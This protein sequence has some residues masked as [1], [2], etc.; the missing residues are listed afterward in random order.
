MPSRKVCIPEYSVTELAE[1]SDANASRIVLPNDV[2]YLVRAKHT[3]VAGYLRDGKP[4]SL[5]LRFQSF[6]IIFQ[7]DGKPWD[8][9]NVF[10]FK[11]LENTSSPN[12]GTFI[13][14]AEDLAAY[15]RFIESVP[16][17]W[18]SFP[19]HRLAR[20]T[21][22]YR[23]HLIHETLAGELKASTA[24]RRIGVVV[25]FYRW[26]IE[27]GL[28][29]PDNPPWKDKVSL[30][31][32][33]GDYGQPGVMRIKSTD[34]R[35][36]VPKQDDPTNE[37]ICDG[38]KLRPL[39]P[40]EQDWLVEALEEVGNTEL[41]MIHLFALVTGARI[42]T[43]LT[44]KVRN[45]M[46]LDC[47]DKAPMCPVGPGTG[48]DTKNNKKMTLCI[49][50]WFCESLLTYVLSERARKRRLSAIGGDA[51]DQY[52]FLTVHGAPMYVSKQDK[53]NVEFRPR[54]HRI[55]GQ[56]VRQ[57]IYDSVIPLIRE[58]HDAKFH[59]RFHDLRASYGMNIVDHLAPLIDSGKISYTAALNFVRTRLGHESLSTT[60]RYLKYR[61]NQKMAR[62]VQDEW[63]SRLQQMATRVMGQ[64]NAKI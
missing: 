16:I 24:N 56:A 45:V 17:D 15:R 51:D 28:M 58:K 39:S 43:I 9:A 30:V 37:S 41:T 49:P 33:R 52:L 8:E 40:T 18:L 59:Y 64:G 32:T 7:G 14:M 4:T 34:L 31:S 19:A 60:E 5:P 42:Q 20:P 12:M 36:N 10:L 57:N 53:A 27:E 54:R 2:T 62:R 26:I 61:A 3:E 13:G 48:V 55:A 25:R 38:G 1:A 44:F 35:I 47:S 6:P 29:T 46:K 11:M 63:E 50:P 22:R 21:Y 23:S